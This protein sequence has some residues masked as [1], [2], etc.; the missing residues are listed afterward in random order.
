MHFVTDINHRAST[1]AVALTRAQFLSSPEC[2]PDISDEGCCAPMSQLTTLKSLDGSH[3]PT[4]PT[5]GYSHWHL[6][7]A[8]GYTSANDVAEVRFYCT[9]SNHARVMHFKTSNLYVRARAV[10]GRDWRGWNRPSNW[11]TGWTGLSNHTA[12][13]PADT[14]SGSSYAVLYNN[15]FSGNNVQWNI[16]NSQALCDDNIGVKKSSHQ[17]WVRFDGALLSTLILACHGAHKIEVS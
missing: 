8:L 10:Y 14:T 16:S 3:L 1:D 15:P 7:P 2:V 6:G 5:T 4:S 12:Y 9:T 13:L 17:I 11:N